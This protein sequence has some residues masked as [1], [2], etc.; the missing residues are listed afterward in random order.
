MKMSKVLLHTFLSLHVDS[1]SLQVLDFVKA[2][3]KRSNHFSRYWK[4]HIFVKGLFF[5]FPSLASSSICVMDGVFYSSVMSSL[6]IRFPGY[7]MVVLIYTIEP[8]E[9]FMLF[10]LTPLCA[11]VV[12]YA[13]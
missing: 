6:L 7:M 2:V 4:R 11:W 10:Y 9:F 5:T 13:I 8:R 12:V 3:S 1:L